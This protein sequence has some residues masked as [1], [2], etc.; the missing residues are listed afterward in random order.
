M[1]WKNL[2]KGRLAEPGDVPE[3]AESNET[4]VMCVVLTVRPDER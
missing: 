3:D 2:S 4:Y 1:D